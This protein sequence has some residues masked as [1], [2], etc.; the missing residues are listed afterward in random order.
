MSLLLISGYHSMPAT[1]RAT[2]RMITAAV[3]WL[4]VEGL[5]PRNQII[6]M[7]YNYSFVM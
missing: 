3:G 5:L 6:L 7:G 2:A 1:T 4:V